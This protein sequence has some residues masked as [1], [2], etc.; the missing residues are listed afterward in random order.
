M[1]S[2]SYIGIDVD[3]KNFSIA[4]FD[5]ITGKLVEKR[6]RPNVKALVDFIRKWPTK[7]KLCYEAGF[8]GFSLARSLRN[9]GFHC[10][11]IA[12]S[13]VPQLSGDRVKTDRLDA[14]KLARFYANGLLTSVHIPEPQDEAVRGIVRSRQFTIKQRTQIKNR[15]TGLCRSQ[16]WDFKEEK[17]Q[18]SYWTTL[19]FQ[20]LDEKINSGKCPVLSTHL[21]LL[22]K[23]YRQIDALIKEY[24]EI[25]IKLCEQDF[26]T[27][28]VKALNCF[29]SIDTMTAMT[30]ITEIGDI[31]RFD[32]PSKI[33]SFAG[34][35]IC[36]YSS[37]GQHRRFKITKLGNP[38]LRYALIESSQFALN[39]PNISRKLKKRRE[40]V[41]INYIEI[42]DRCMERL[43]SKGSRLLYKGKQKNKIKVA[44]ARE[45]IGFI[46][47]TL[48][49]TQNLE[50]QIKVKR[51]VH[52]K[53][54]KTQPTV[55]A[56]SQP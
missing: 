43:Y 24:E 32:H 54:P 48:R 9:F 17:N 8:L 1:S 18:I 5:P 28:K 14:E 50:K 40:G 33:T 22:L 37:G 6:L 34:M 12:P 10:D 45:L 35:D 51:T 26:Y 19:H 11:V 20:W 44:M 42:A 27:E 49:V 36:E 52:L 16:G 53:K 30:L 25:I 41:N 7:V 13:L 47:E 2:V 38:Y 3:T 29:R 55:G 56:I 31:G 21:E 39:K 15:I 46:W 4:I 23:Q